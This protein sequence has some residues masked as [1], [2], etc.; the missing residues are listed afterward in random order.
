LQRDLNTIAKSVPHLQTREA[1]NLKRRSDGSFAYDGHVFQALVRP[2]GQVDFADTSEQA[3]FMLPL[4]IRAVA[5]VNDLVEKQVLG[6]ELYSA[7]KAWFLEQTREL[8]TQLAAAARRRELQQANRALERTLQDV[9]S[10][11]ALSIAQKHDAVFL[12][13]QDC[14]EDAQQ[15]AHRRSVEAFVRRYMPRGS[16]LGFHADELERFN[17]QRGAL[18]KFEPY[19]DS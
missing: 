1:P 5:D 7:E 19:S 10:D 18:Q 3:H 8:R 16:P 11:G 2:D 4:T 17:A 14:G 13:W 15:K 12:L 6:R 9:L